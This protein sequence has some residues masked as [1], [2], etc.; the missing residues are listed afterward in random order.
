M[1]WES[2]DDRNSKNYRLTTIDSQLRNM[3][4]SFK[5]QELFKLIACY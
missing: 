2:V 4:I 1:S 3:F 5:R